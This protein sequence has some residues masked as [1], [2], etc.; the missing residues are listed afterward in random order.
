MPQDG[1]INILNLDEEYRGP[2]VEKHDRDTTPNDE[3]GAVAAKYLMNIVHRS[4]PKVRVKASTHS[5]V[6]GVG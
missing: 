2:P 4:A 5:F 1:T 3:P 6:W